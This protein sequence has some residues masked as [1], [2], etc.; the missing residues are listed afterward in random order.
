MFVQLIIFFFLIV[1]PFFLISTLPLLPT[2]L[3]S[4]YLSFF[5]L[6]AFVF[7]NDERRDN[8]T[9][10][11]DPFGIEEFGSV[12][13]PSQTC[14]EQRITDKEPPLGTQSRQNQETRL[15]DMER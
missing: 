11:D 4:P 13:F 14:L 1:S 2:P 7:W 3:P 12:G 8:Y 10:E 6:A 9:T 15:A 5:P